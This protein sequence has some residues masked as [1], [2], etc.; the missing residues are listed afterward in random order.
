[1]PLPLKG[2][3]EMKKTGAIPDSREVGTQNVRL[4]RIQEVISRTGLSR[5]GIYAAI[6]AGK[7]PSQV[8]ILPDGRLAGWVESEIDAWLQTRIATARNTSAPAI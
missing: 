7:F 4:I 2:D 5:S 3:I 1:V 6:K 8:Q